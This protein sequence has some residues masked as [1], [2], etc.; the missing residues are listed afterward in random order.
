MIYSKISVFLFPLPVSY[1]SFAK[2]NPRK[3]NEIS[4]DFIIIINFLSYNFKCTS[5]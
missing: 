5:A 4:N 1:P 3:D 2:I